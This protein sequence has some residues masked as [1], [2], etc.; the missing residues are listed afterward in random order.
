MLYAVLW[1][2]C[3]WEYIYPWHSCLDGVHILIKNIDSVNH[4]KIAKNSWNAANVI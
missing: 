1:Q 3:Y 4:V 2:L